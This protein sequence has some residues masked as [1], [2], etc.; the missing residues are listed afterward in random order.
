MH[1]QISNF[2]RYWERL[3]KSGSD[4]RNDNYLNPQFVSFACRHRFFSV[5]KNV[6]F[7]CLI[8]LLILFFRICLIFPLLI[9][10]AWKKMNIKWKTKS[11]NLV[12]MSLIQFLHTRLVFLLPINLNWKMK[13][14]RQPKEKNL[15][16]M[17]VIVIL[18]LHTVCMLMSRYMKFIWLCL[19]IYFFYLLCSF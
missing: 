1:R 17:S 6:I 11:S 13:I 14:L 16:L 18:Q 7:N 19:F 5:S 3:K 4:R 2:Q 9:Y 15:V 12:P 10:L 8:G